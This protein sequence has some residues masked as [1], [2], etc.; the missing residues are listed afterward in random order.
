MKKMT[1]YY[2]MFNAIYSEFSLKINYIGRENEQWLLA[3]KERVELS[4]WKPY[5][6]TWER[7]RT[8]LPVVFINVYVD[9]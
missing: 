2:I 5:R 8:V 6:E 3:M 1:K 7:N 9:L 4:V